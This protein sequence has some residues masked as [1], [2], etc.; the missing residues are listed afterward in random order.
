MTHFEKLASPISRQPPPPVQLREDELDLF[1]IFR[2][3]RRRKLLITLVALIVIGAALPSILTAQRY[4]FAQSRLLLQ[5]PITTTLAAPTADEAGAFDLDTELQRLLSRDIAVRVIEQFDLGSRPEFNPALRPVPP[6]E[7]A[8][9]SVRQ[10]LGMETQPASDV[11]VTEQVIEA[12]FGALNV[13]RS[14]QSQVVQVGF[15]SL[16]PALAADVANTLVRVYL[17]ERE[18]KQR[19]RLKSGDDWFAAQIEEQRR[20]AADVDREMARL[21]DSRGLASDAQANATST[22]ATLTA[23]RAALATERAGLTASIAGLA[24]AKDPTDA[25]EVIDTDAMEGL[26]RELQLQKQ[27][28][29]KLLLNYGN[30]HESVIEARA[31]IGESEAA[32]AGEV[33]RYTQ[34]LQSQAAGLDR[35]D[36]QVT[37]QLQVAQAALTGL[38]KA[39]TGLGL[40]QDRSKQEHED[41]DALERRRRTLQSQ[42]KLPVAE[43][44]VLTPAAIPVYPEGRGRSLYLIVA[45]IAAGGLWLYRCGHRRPNGSR[46]PQPAAARR[47]EWDPPGRNDSG[48]VAPP[49][50]VAR[51]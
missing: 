8:R 7:S 27:E 39:E 40:L 17:D 25:A 42:L 24:A 13:Y 3:I 28:L 26:R 20:R 34:S 14:G 49:A 43:A 41:L 44:E 5:R 23:R 33:E 16:D 48:A 37:A 29:S 9:R 50:K 35:E 2:L 38:D 19:A 6:V 46:D 32:I 21:R 12:Y 18:Q 45:I 51:T 30:A 22:I 47:H 31:R 1:A 10:W 4:Y 11:D 36:A 15:R